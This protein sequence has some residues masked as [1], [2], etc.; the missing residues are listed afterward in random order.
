MSTNQ[1]PELLIVSMKSR[2]RRS[3][4]WHAV[5]IA[6][7]LGLCWALSTQT[8]LKRDPSRS[9]PAL[10]TVVVDEG[11]IAVVVTENGSIES[12]VDDV[13]RCRVEAFQRL[14]VD[15]PVPREEPPAPQAR[16]ARTGGVRTGQT[17][18]S[19]DRALP[20]TPSAKG[21]AMSR[22]LE[23]QG[24]PKSG[25]TLPGASVG[26][27]P[28]ASAKAGRSSVALSS[29]SAAAPPDFSTAPKR[30]AIRS[31]EHVVEPHIPLRVT[32][33]NQGV[34]ASTAP[35][36]PTILSILPEGSRVKAGDVVCVLDSSALTDA[37]DV[38]KLRYVQARA[39]LEQAK[40]ILAAEEI[41]LRE[42]EAGV[43]PQDIQFVRHK[44]GICETERARAE[45]NL[46]WSRSALA[47]GFR[48]EAQVEAD[49]SMLEQAQ[50]ALRD[51]DV[52]LTRLVKYTGKRILKAH[53]AKIEAIHADLLSL[54]FS[55]RLETE[56]LKRI[57]AMIANCTMRAPR[58][59]IVVYAAGA[60]GWGTGETQ[61]REGLIVHQSQPIF[62][63]LD[64]SHLQVRAKIN[65]SQLARIKPGQ[66][67]LIHLEAFPDHPMR[68]SVAAIVPIP[69]LASGPFPDVR[70]FFATVRIESGGFDALTT[71]LTAKLEI[72]VETRRQVTR[73]PLEAICWAGDRSFAATMVDAEI[74]PNWRWRP[75]VLGLTDT[76]FA[77]V[78]SGL[79]PGDRVI[80]HSEDL[81]ATELGSSE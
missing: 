7:A 56:R 12:S 74:K 29:L 43:L 30:L 14:P 17:S 37:L 79:E 4:W 5:A 10:E 58:G 21:S 36:P 61:I 26:S 65:E 15:S 39:W 38:Q 47:K 51:A 18:S 71:G 59:G 27:L 25:A 46:A 76:T 63:L 33:P 64:P 28:G 9:L 77:E 45:R 69:S 60:G 57:E 66:P 32:L 22:R 24:V 52:M 50:I 53:R 80:A 75:V 72:L 3:D 23:G 48:S 19:R 70:T 35:G 62:R 73:V 1:D 11:D 55:F 41:A 78:I 42:Y 13:I 49:L 16:I 2:R 68:G 8:G 67:V 20:A 44:I 6:G 34:V 81:P 40:Y 54:E 31:F